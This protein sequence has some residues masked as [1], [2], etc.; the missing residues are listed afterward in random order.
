MWSA[1]LLQVPL[2]RLAALNRPELPAALGG[3]VGSGALGL[4]MPAFAIA[5]SAL[6]NVFYLPG[7]S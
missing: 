7:E 1:P 3:L 6:I 5:F 2:S 4:M